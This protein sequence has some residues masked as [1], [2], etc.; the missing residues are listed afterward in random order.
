MPAGTVMVIMVMVVMLM[1]IMNGAVRMFVAGMSVSQSMRV[2]MF[3]IMV[4]FMIV[5]VRQAERVSLFMRPPGKIRLEAL[6]KQRP[7]DPHDRET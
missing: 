2:L 1:V 7:A 3:V 5:L 4:M 6:N